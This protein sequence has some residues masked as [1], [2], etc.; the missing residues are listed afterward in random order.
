MAISPTQQVES[1]SAIASGLEFSDEGSLVAVSEEHRSTLTKQLK[2]LARGP[3]PTARFIRWFLSP[4]SDRTIFPA[5]DV[6]AAG[7][8][9]NALLLDS[10]VSEGWVRNALAFLPDQPLLH[11]GPA[12]FEPDA[13][14][15]NFLRSSGAGRLP[16]NG[17]V[18]RRAGEMLRAQ[19]SFEFALVAVDKALSA[20]PADLAAQRL[21]RE[22][23]DAMGR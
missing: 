20:D 14:R 6:K 3:G 9:E 13:Q 4:G 1:I 19:R 10:N 22:V 17:V 21:R 23:L 5:S 12:G 18:C 7:W 8:V 16:K 15:A 11:V 2:D